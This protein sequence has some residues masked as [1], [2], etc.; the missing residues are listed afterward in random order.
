MREIVKYIFPFYSNNTLNRQVSLTVDVLDHID[1]ILTPWSC[2]LPPSE[3]I[4][5]ACSSIHCVH[6]CIFCFDNRHWMSSTCN[7]R[8]EFLW[9]FE[10]VK[11]DAFSIFCEME[12]Q[13]YSTSPS[14]S[15]TQN[16]GLNNYYHKTVNFWAS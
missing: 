12:F 14:L 7:F 6:F 11:L 2:F 13:T 8:S 5:T 4:N 16:H 1:G 10:T 9:E 15:T 3:P